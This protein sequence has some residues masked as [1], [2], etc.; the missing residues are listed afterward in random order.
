MSF[1]ALLVCQV[2]ISMLEKKNS[3]ITADYSVELKYFSNHV[4]HAE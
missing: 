4:V 3:D 2:Q 1:S